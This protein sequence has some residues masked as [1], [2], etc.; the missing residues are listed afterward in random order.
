MINLKSKLR[1]DILRI[2]F[3]R[4]ENEYY[5]REL[6]R[7]LKRPAAYVRR[8]LLA[9]EKTGLFTSEVKGKQK[10]FRLN[11]DYPLYSEIKAIVSKTIG[12]EASLKDLLLKIPYIKIA[13]IFGSF[14]EGTEDLLS[15]IDLMI[16]GNPD[17][18]LLVD[19]IS[20]LEQNIGREINYHIYSTSDFKEKVKKRDYFIQTVI[21]SKKTLIIG[22]QDELQRASR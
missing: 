4:P 10:Y 2:Y 12:I 9:L 20:N 18:D 3:A 8:E 1:R 14:A 19:K 16:I 6:E 7:M 13:F 21:A 11:K 15:D 22:S 17:E 5:I